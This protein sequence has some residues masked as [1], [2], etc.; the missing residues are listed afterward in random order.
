ME[1]MQKQKHQIHSRIT[2]NPATT[3]T[4]SQQIKGAYGKRD[5]KEKRYECISIAARKGEIGG[6]NKQTENA[7]TDKSDE[8]FFSEQNYK[9]D[10]GGKEYRIVG[11]P[12]VC[13][14]NHL[15]SQN[16]QTENRTEQQST[17]EEFQLCQGVV[18]LKS[19]LSEAETA[20]DEIVP[21]SL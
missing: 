16:H 4:S 7:M 20:C 3:L 9:T 21:P 2:G 1:A 15:Y 11:K 5:E 6:Q 18:L 19:I 14:G 17:V 8:L 10:E 12:A 13:T